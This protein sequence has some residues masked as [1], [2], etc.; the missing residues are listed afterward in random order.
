MRQRVE[1]A[2]KYLLS[3]AETLWRVRVSLS[4]W[5]RVLVAVFS[6]LALPASAADIIRWWVS[7]VD[8]K[9]QL[10]EQAPLEWKA[11]PADDK[12][13]IEINPSVEFQK[14][15]G[16]GSSLEP[17][18]CSNLWR[19][20][21]A[22]RERTIERLVSPTAG[23]GM[24]LMRICIGTPDF[25][26]DPWYSYND[27]LRGETDPEL[28]RFSIEKDRGYILPVLKLARQKNPDLLFFASPWSPPGW[29]KSTGTM[30][31]GHLLPQWY[32]AYAE[33]SVK[34]IQAYEAEGIPI[35]AVT[36]QNEPGVDRAKERN[37]KWFYPSC[38]WTGEQE[39]DFIR[40]HLGPAFRRHR[41]T[42]RIW[43]YDHNYNLK[44]RGAD[45]GIAY[46]RT[47]LRDPAAAQFV[48]GVAF[49]GYA[50]GPEGMS[51]LHREFPQ[52]PLYFTEGSVFDLKGGVDL[53]EKLRN[54]A[55]GYN[56][57]VTIL[58][59]NGKPNNGP[60]D[61]SRTLI[62]LNPATGKPTEHFDFFLYGHFMK[63]IQRGAVRV[64][65]S[66]LRGAPNV[67]FRNPD[68]NLVLVVA[69][70]GGSEQKFA[71]QNAG[72]SVSAS[73][74]ARSIGTYL[75]RQAG[76]EPAPAPPASG[77]PASK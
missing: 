33:Y 59:D 3:L 31:G 17:S 67:A 5:R 40:D 8:L 57:W 9:Q 38:H 71:I 32:A 44:T 30:I 6:A 62:T 28:K 73:L 2:I 68:G 43:C 66:S 20:T 12:D 39:R 11:G 49:H 45:P 19:M 47:I 4:A 46:P 14:M 10:A 76:Q 64:D 41:L 24:N 61:A 35:H 72:H 55:S 18:T 16:L 77:E 54:W 60:F 53:I 34:F 7:S 22:D 36:I 15:L 51:E 42:T 70:A 65:S 69:T 21:P 37:P 13:R 1:L 63:F 25:T 26:G 56:A 23:I 74:P 75:W 48:S 27:L 50:G 52:V 58:D 29:M